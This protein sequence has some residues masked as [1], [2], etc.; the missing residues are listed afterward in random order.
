MDRQIN[1]DGCDGSEPLPEHL[2]KAR[3]L[4]RKAEQAQLE[5]S[6]LGKD[7]ISLGPTASDESHISASDESHISASSSLLRGSSRRTV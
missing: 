6:D 1:G 4:I 3:A 5:K 7:Y 2:A